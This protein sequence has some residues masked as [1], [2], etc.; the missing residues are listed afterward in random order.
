MVLIFEEIGNIMKYG[1]Y[2]AVKLHVHCM[3]VVER[4][5]CRT[6]TVSKMQFGFMPER[7]TIDI[8]IEGYKNSIMLREKSVLWT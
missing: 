2:K 6:L 4:I 7:G 5:P 1:C 3:K 8:V